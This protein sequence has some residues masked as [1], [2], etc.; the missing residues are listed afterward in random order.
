LPKSFAVHTKGGTVL[1][2]EHLPSRRIPPR[3]ARFPFAS[4]RVISGS[5]LGLS[6]NYANDAKGR[7]ANP[8]H[9]SRFA[10]AL[11]ISRTTSQL[12]ESNPPFASF[13]YLA[14][15]PLSIWVHPRNALNPRKP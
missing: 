2:N 3:L 7:N 9:G 1:A 4:I 5:P 6:A 11:H 10:R 15:H 12:T 13:A 14:D 8:L